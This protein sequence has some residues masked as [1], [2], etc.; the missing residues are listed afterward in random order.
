VASPAEAPAR[1]SRLRQLLVGVLVVL[2]CVT[3]TAATA[4]FWVNRN[5]LKTSV[6]VK[7]VGP[8]PQD[9]AVQDAL[10]RQLTAQTMSLID[11]K[12][13]FSEALPER[14]QILAVPLSNAV[15]GFVSDRVRAFLA[16]DAFN[17]LWVGLNEQAHRQ[18]VKALRGETRL[19]EARE[20]EV[21]IN[22]VP[23][24]NSLLAQFQQV[25]PELF[26]RKLDL[27]NLTVG[28]LPD[29]AR[30]AL[31][32]A[33]GRPINDDFGTITVY[34]TSQLKTAQT[35]VK[36]F[37]TFFAATVVLSLLLIPLTIWL[38]RRRRRTALQMLFGIALGVVFIRRAAFWVED[39]VLDT[40]RRQ[41]NL[42]AV[43]AILR[44]FL[45]PL[46]TGSALI[47]VLLGALTAGLLLTG[48]YAWAA[49]V[50]ESLAAAGG[51]TQPTEGTAVWVREHRDLLQIGGGAVFV[52]GIL[53]VDVSW[54][55]LIVML[56]LLVAYEAAV[57]RAAGAG[58]GSGSAPEPETPVAPIT[59]TPATAA[60][61]AGTSTTDVPQG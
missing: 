25:T 50:R 4:G 59:G 48:P 14:G 27:P 33:L 30:Q 38:S 60:A 6:W 52:L 35:A 49:R 29:E 13:L 20:Q 53:A 22:L 10:T 21:V 8:L 39:G 11:P 31:S 47:L 34:E 46:V 12:T 7:R 17:T 2:T 24:I 41:E 45:D 32:N 28:S 15:Q 36:A 3:V 16:S 1:P 54:P 42:A 55:V 43:R 5:F 19:V 61:G 9:P 57:V 40:V 18:A 51:R 58:S 44:A 26:G 56:G 37:D 23:V